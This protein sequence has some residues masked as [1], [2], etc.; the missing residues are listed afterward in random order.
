MQSELLVVVKLMT[1]VKVKA[2][3]LQV[4]SGVVLWSFLYCEFVFNLTT[5]AIMFVMILKL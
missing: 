4:K 1:H 3:K 5:T 2:Q